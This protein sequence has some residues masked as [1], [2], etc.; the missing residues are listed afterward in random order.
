MI[1]EGINLCICQDS[2]GVDDIEATVVVL[3]S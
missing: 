3:T 2:N 1:L